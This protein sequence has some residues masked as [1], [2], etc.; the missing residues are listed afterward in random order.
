[1]LKDKDKFGFIKSQVVAAYTA[2]T[3]ALMLGEMTNVQWDESSQY[4]LTGTF[5]LPSVG[6]SRL[7]MAEFSTNGNVVLDV[8]IKVLRNLANMLEVVQAKGT[9][10]TS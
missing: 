10:I 3:Q 1:M 5:D 7:R 9:A 4:N 6:L 2:I 8:R